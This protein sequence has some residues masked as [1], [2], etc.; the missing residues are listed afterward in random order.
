MTDVWAGSIPKLQKGASGFRD[1][2]QLMEHL[3]DQLSTEE[4]ELFWVQC[5]LIWNQ[6]N[7]V[8][9]GRQLKNPTSLNKRAEEFLQ[10]FKQAQVHLTVSLMEQPS[11]EVWQPPSPMVYKLN[12]D[13]A[14]FLGMEKSGI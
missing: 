4:M 1:V 3:V 8:P 2:M 9:Y 5:W 12:F 7:C 6:R 13:A 14:I 10:E 11:D